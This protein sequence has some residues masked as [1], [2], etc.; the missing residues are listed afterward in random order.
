MVRPLLPSRVRGLPHAAAVFVGCAAGSVVIGLYGPLA[1]LGARSGFPAAV[2]LFD[3]AVAV[4]CAC[5]AIAVARGRICTGRGLELSASLALCTLYWATLAEMVGEPSH[6][7]PLT[8]HCCL[9][10]VVAGVVIRSRAALVGLAAGA[11][12]SWAIAAVL[13]D[14]AGL[15]PS[16]WWSTWV[17]AVVVAF[18]AQLITGAERGVQRRV[19]RDAQ[20][21]SLVDPLTGL[22]NRR[23]F[24]TQAQSVLALAQRTGQPLW[25]AFIDVDHFKSVNDRLG[26]EAG[27][28]VLVA[29]ASALR[30]VA[31]VSDVPARWGGDE[32]VL[33]GHGAPPDERDL[34]ERIAGQL[35]QLPRGIT[36]VWPPSVTVGSAPGTLGADGKPVDL[37]G[38]VDQADRGMYE[39]RRRS[40]TTP[41]TA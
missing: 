17:I 25:C 32:F 6:A 33:L 37:A 29:V 24:R 19:R 10:L 9:L 13:I 21:S 11:V 39:R 38:L 18:A 14:S 23:G 41:A 12:A 16:L 30:A 27:D 7:Q 5:L 28:L 35:R 1:W 22:A 4:V 40:R 31:R 26:H 2:A 34:E 3:V 36:E 20:T 15:D 8:A